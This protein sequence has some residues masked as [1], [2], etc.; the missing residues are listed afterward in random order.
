MFTPSTVRV[1]PWLHTYC[2]SCGNKAVEREFY[3]PMGAK[4]KRW[5]IKPPRCACGHPLFFRGQVAETLYH[6]EDFIGGY[7]FTRALEML[8]AIFSSA[9]A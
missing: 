1:A 8:E 5:H 3:G 2:P 9:W 7:P 6:E 4:I